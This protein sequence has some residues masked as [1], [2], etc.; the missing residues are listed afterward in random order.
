MRI[1]ASLAGAEATGATGTVAGAEATG[2][3]GT[4]AGATDAAGATY[5]SLILGGPEY[6]II[7]GCLPARP[8]FATGTAAGTATGTAAGIFAVSATAD[9]ASAF[10]FATQSAG[11]VGKV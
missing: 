1:V 11:G 6:F 4:V 7:L 5:A 2:A 10:A 3:T 8:R 9:C